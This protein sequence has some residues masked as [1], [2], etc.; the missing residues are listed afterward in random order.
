MY[1]RFFIN[2]LRNRIEGDKKISKNN[3][4]ETRLLFWNFSKNLTNFLRN[5][6]CLK[7]VKGL[8]SNS[9]CFENWLN[10]FE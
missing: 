1:C 4:K 8:I 5:F 7:F 6:W 10:Y 9:V 2:I 3:C